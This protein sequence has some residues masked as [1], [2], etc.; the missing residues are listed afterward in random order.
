MADNANNAG[1]GIVQFHFMYCIL[2]L[3]N[4][5][6]AVVNIIGPFAHTHFALFHGGMCGC[7]NGTLAVFLTDPFVHFLLQALQTLIAYFFSFHH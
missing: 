2:D 5:F 4:S 6:K 7:R 1:G 3:S